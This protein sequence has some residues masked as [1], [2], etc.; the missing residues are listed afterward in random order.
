VSEDREPLLCA[1]CGRQ[2]RDEE[3]PEDEWRSYSDGVGELHTFCPECA[4]REFGLDAPGSRDVH[5]THN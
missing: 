5:P 1:E 2:P 4:E 3:R